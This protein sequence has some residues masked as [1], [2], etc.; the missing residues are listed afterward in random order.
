MARLIALALLLSLT[1]CGDLCRACDQDNMLACLSPTMV[2]CD[3][4][5]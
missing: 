1:A 5:E 3:D 2:F 4:K